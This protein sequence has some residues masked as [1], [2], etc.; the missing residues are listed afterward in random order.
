MTVFMV[1]GL[2]ACGETDNTEPQKEITDIAVYEDTQADILTADFYDLEDGTTVSGCRIPSLSVFSTLL[3]AAHCRQSCAVL[4]M[5]AKTA[6]GFLPR[7]Q[8][9]DQS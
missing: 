4:L 9:S 1:I 2:A 8:V 7:K 6:Y 3:N 5:K